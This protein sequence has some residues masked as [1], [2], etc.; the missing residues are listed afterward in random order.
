MRP[1]EASEAWEE[2]RAGI[3]TI[4]KPTAA[5]VSMNI[6]PWSKPTHFGSREAKKLIQ[7]FILL[8]LH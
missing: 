5:I 2:V 4:M 6:W 1:A 8:G 7:L 3:R